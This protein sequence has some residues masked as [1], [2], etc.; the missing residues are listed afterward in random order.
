M[1]DDDYS[2][3]YLEFE[4]ISGYRFRRQ[5]K[6][7]PIDF[8]QA[9]VVTWTV[10]NDER[11]QNFLVIDGETM[12]YYPEDALKSLIGF[13]RKRLV[14]LYKE[15]DAASRGEGDSMLVD[16]QYKFEREEDIGWSIEKYDQ[17]YRQAHKYLGEE[18]SYQFLK[19][20]RLMG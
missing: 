7:S 16:E 1:S 8:D 2:D 20:R 5:L 10:P 11:P 13:C 15:A 12:F 14:Q 4:K 17:L 6:S 3:A 19:D 9:G 18:P